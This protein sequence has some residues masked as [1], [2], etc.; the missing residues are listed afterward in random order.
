M[1]EEFVFLNASLLFLLSLRCK[2][3]RAMALG[4]ERTSSSPERWRRDSSA[5]SSSRS[6]LSCV[7]GGQIS[8][9]GCKGLRQLPSTLLRSLQ[10][11]VQAVAPLCMELEAALIENQGE[12]CARVLS[13]ISHTICELNSPHLQ[14]NREAFVLFGGDVLLLRCLFCPFATTEG[15]GSGGGSAGAAGSEKMVSIKLLS[16]QKECLNILRELC[17]TVTYFTESLAAHDDFVINLF[18][19]MGFYSTFE[20]GKVLLTIWIV[21]WTSPFCTHLHYSP[22]FLLWLLQASKHN[23]LLPWLF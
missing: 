17:F 1:E 3:A 19:L 2:F 18:G 7:L 5:R 9:R 4:C 15:S 23:F 20:Y 16:L 22:Q 10:P 13:T 12:A 6:V 11:S 21:S 14:L 8:G